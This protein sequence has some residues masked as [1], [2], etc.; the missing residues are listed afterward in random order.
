MK[1]SLLA[2]IRERIIEEKSYIKRGNL[3]NQY[4]EEVIKII[5]E[6]NL[7][8]RG[9]YII[10]VAEL[11]HTVGFM[12]GLIEKVCDGDMSLDELREINTKTKNQ[13][14]EDLNNEIIN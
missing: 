3:L 10:E 1:P 9:Q 11:R 12:A 14:E 8:L 13:T 5:N 6:D 7:R 2:E 4:T